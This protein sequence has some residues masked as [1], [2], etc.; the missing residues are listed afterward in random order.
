MDD[1]RP[2]PK[3]YSTGLAWLPELPTGWHI[4]RAKNSFREVDDRSEQGD[5]E[6][7]SV[8]HKTG[9]TPRSEKN[10]TMFMAESY[11]GHKVCRPGDIVVNTMWAW[12]AAIGV[13]RQIGIVSPSYGVYRPRAADAFEPRYLDYLLRTEIYRAEYVRSSRGITTSRLRLYPPDFLNIPFVQAPIDE[14]R[15]IVRFLAWHSAQTAKL[16][17]A[18]KQVVAL[19]NEQKQAI[20]RRAVTGGLDPNAKLKPSGVP[21]LGDIPEGWEVKRL[22]WAMR[23]QRGYDLPADKRRPGPFPVVS[24]GGVI[25]RHDQCKANAPGVVMGRYGSTDAVFYLEEDFWPH[26]TSLFVTSFQGNEPRWCYYVLR[27]I[28]K[29]D[30]ASKSAV[31]GLDRKDLFDI[32]L[33][34]PPKEEQLRIILGIE[35]R[36]R[37]LK[38]AISRVETEIALVQAFR[39]RLIA[40]VV[41]GKLDVRTAAAKLPE[42]TD[43]EVI[44]EPF[45]G[46]EFEEAI[47]EID[48][49][50][51]AA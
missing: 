8:S 5:E 48:A 26:N 44:D 15:L 40:D 13:S 4:D 23:L 37:E 10:I 49:E 51:V 1:L 29:A 11:E 25:G 21:W 24:S 16:I 20:I 3:V 12:M 47:D 50:E 14:Q 31:P 32:I 34:V 18:K 41:T 27:T 45:G 22:K 33:A 36:S 6:L 30:Y 35:D 38:V 7:L 9:V 17:R 19:L 39:T 28:S 42:V 2:Y 46:E 43:V